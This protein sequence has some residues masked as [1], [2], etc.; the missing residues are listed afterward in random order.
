MEK[1][2]HFE[3]YLSGKLSDADKKAFENQLTE[4]SEFK[5]DFEMHKKMQGAMD[6]LVE[7]DAMQFISSLDKPKIQS[8]VKSKTKN[9]WLVSLVILILALSALFMLF[10]P[11]GQREENHMDAYM[12]PL[13]EA[14]RS[15]NGQVTDETSY[16]LQTKEAHDLI[17]AKKYKKAASLLEAQLTQFKGKEKQE[18]EWYLALLYST[19]EMERSRLLLYRIS[20][21]EGHPYARKAKGLID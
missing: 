9:K 11:F 10:N 21:E 1:F 20:T 4:D 3:S 14:T 18:I 6:I 17:A 5:S 8:E 15:A 13:A 7:E 12:A 19:Y 16:Y 2:E